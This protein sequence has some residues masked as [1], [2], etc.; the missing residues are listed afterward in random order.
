MFSDDIEIEI[1]LL[2]N[3]SNIGVCGGDG[4]GG[5]GGYCSSCYGVGVD[6]DGSD[7]VGGDGVGEYIKVWYILVWCQY[8]VILC[9]IEWAGHD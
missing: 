5:V 9:I 7:G 6:V 3:V 8:C 1:S 4:E 2:Q